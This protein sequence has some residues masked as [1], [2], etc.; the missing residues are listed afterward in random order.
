MLE[1]ARTEKVI[2]FRRFKIDWM[3][4]RQTYL[5]ALTVFILLSLFIVWR[6]PCLLNQK[7][8]TINVD[9][10]GY[11]SLKEMTQSVDVIIVGRVEAIHSRSWS[12]LPFTTF[13]IT[14]LQVVKPSAFNQSEILVRQGGYNYECRTADV[15][16]DPLMNVG[17]K[18]IFFLLRWR[19]EDG[20]LRPEYDRSMGGLSMFLVRDDKVYPRLESWTPRVSGMTI[21]KLIKELETYLN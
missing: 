12:E 2:S 13:N 11:S 16:G 14:V 1:R 5:L 20:T 3:N 7:V 4:K 18:Y 21:D 17:E 10:I 9:Y 8:S 19:N 6:Y 15:V